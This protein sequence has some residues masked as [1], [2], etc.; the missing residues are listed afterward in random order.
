MS[1][2]LKAIIDDNAGNLAAAEREAAKQGKEAAKKLRK[3]KAKKQDKEQVKDPEEVDLEALQQVAA[4]SATTL[5]AIQESIAKATEPK[6]LDRIGNFGTYLMGEMRAMSKGRYKAFKRE[7]QA[8]LLKY[9]SSSEDEVED[10]RQ[11][12]TP[13]KFLCSDTQSSQQFCGSSRQYTQQQSAIGVC[14]GYGEW[15]PHPFN[16]MLN[17]S[18][19]SPWQSAGRGYSNQYY[20]RIQ[21]DQ[22]QQ[23]YQGPLQQLNV[24]KP[25]QSQPQ[26]S[27]S[28]PSSCNKTPDSSNITTMAL[29][30]LGINMDSPQLMDISLLDSL[31]L[32]Y[33]TAPS[34]KECSKSSSK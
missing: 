1:F 30:S 10:E 19:A 15:Q 14:A 4:D 7:V 17:L 13:K 27:Q 25:Q 24:P 5:A 33:A 23:P 6:P 9:Q 21:Q 31:H 26:P 3:D 20:N 11:A 28:Q 32:P 22:Q 29:V 8:L 12:P 2:Q 16:R 34:T 18:P